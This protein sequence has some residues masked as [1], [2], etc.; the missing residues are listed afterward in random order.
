MR[1]K[2]FIA[3]DKVVEKLKEDGIRDTIN[4]EDFVALCSEAL[5]IEATFE[6]YEIWI[7]EEY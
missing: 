2:D 4:V 3:L 5:W 1:P 7:L 6:D